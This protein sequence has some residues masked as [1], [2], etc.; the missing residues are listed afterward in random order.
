MAITWADLDT[1]GR[2]S[3]GEYHINTQDARP[4]ALPLRRIAWI[5]KDKITQ[6]VEKM[7]QQGI[8]EDSEFS[9]VEPPGFGAEKRMDLFRFCIDYR[10]LNEITVPDKYPLPRI[11][12]VLDTLS[13]ERYFSVIDLK[14]GY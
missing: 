11:D 7:K 1:I 12:D 5:E 13:H 14:A 4:I 9:M 6:E 3:K 8:I 2:T 10:R